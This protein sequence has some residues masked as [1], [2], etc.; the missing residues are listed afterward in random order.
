MPVAA[1][2]ASYHQMW[3]HACMYGCTATSTRALA[4]MIAGSVRSDGGG[5]CRGSWWVLALH[6]ESYKSLATPSGFWCAHRGFHIYGNDV[7]MW[8]TPR[9]SPKVFTLPLRYE[10][11]IFTC[12]STVAAAGHTFSL[13]KAADG[14][15]RPR[16][17]DRLL[18]ATSVPCMPRAPSRRGACAWYRRGGPPRRGPPCQSDVSSWSASAMR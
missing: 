1:A 17:C 6:G 12:E 8:C 16:C 3:L 5:G 10:T 9:T 14:H 11:P 15:T 4:L 13:T 18:K 2:D 7:H